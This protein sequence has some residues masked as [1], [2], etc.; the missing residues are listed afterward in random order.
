MILVSGPSV[1][2]IRPG[3]PESYYLEQLW[4]IRIGGGG[5]SLGD[6]TPNP[7]DESHT[8]VYGV[9]PHRQLKQ[10]AIGL[11]HRADDLT[12]SGKTV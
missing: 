5:Y 7:I 11:S 4:P 6:A 12:V 3:A 9:G 2:R 10:L 8:L 1:S